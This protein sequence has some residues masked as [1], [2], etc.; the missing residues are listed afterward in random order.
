MKKETVFNI[1]QY[2]LNHFQLQNSKYPDSSTSV[3]LVALIP[4]PFSAT[5]N[6]SKMRYCSGLFM[7]LL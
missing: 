7:A 3:L 1:T 5:L 4:P 6:V 2:Q